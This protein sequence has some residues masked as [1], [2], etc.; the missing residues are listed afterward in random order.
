[1]MYYNGNTCGNNGHKTAGMTKPAGNRF[2]YLDWVNNW[3]TVKAMAAYYKRS[4]AQMRAD[5]SAGREAHEAFV[6]ELKAQAKAANPAL[7]ALRY[8][9]TGAIERGEAEAITEKL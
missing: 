4:E 1:M 2:T 8:H 3:L 7:E 5:I 9:I 6:A